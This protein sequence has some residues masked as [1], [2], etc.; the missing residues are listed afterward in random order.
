MAFH[1]LIGT[2]GKSHHKVYYWV[3]RT[4]ENFDWPMECPNTTE[5]EKNVFARI[6]RGYVENG[7][8][9]SD[10]SKFKHVEQDIWEI[11]P[12]MQLRLFGTFKGKA[13]VILYCIRKKKLKI[14]KHDLDT[15]RGLLKQVKEA[16]LEV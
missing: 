14:P 7:R 4:V 16:H 2:N 3:S 5:K 15:T 8:F 9:P 6:V 12:S 10:E 1:L 13:F 11:K